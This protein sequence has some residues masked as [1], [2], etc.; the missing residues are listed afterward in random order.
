MAAEVTGHFLN[1]QKFLS[2]LKKGSKG[3]FMDQ[4]KVTQVILLN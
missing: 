1:K 4:L 2:S 3:N